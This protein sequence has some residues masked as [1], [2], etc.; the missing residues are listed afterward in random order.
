MAVTIELVSDVS[1]VIKGAGKVAER[2]ADVSDS[3]VDLARDSQRSGD[4]IETAMKDAGRSAEHIDDGLAGAGQAADAFEDKARAAF[5]A[6]SDGASKAGDKAAHETKQGFDKSGEAVETFKDEAKS[7]L[8]EVT[9]SFSGD[10][11]SAVDLIQGTLGGLVADLGP[12][13]LVGGAVAALAIGLAKAAADGEAERVNRIGEAAA[14][15]AADI[16]AVGGSLRD[17]DFDDRMHE[18][19]M[20]IQD[21]REWWELWQDK[22]LTGSQLIEKQAKEAGLGFK[23]MF[24]GASGSSEDA[25]KALKQID[26]VLG[27]LQKKTHT[28]TF[29]EFGREIEATDPALSK[30]IKALEDLRGR[31][32]ENITVQEDAAHVSDLMA[33]ADVALAGE[34]DKLKEATDKANDELER[35]AQA[36]DEAAGAAMDS[37]SAELD[38]NEKLKQNTE[39]I[40]ANGKATDTKSAAGIANNK[41]LLDSAQ[42]SL[43]LEAAMIREGAA[44][45]DVTA[46][47]QASR[48]AFIR[49]A[50]AAGYTNEEAR[51]LADR[52]GL[53][54]KNVDTKVQAHNVQQ[55]K[56]EINGL[57]APV[58]VPV[59]PVIPYQAKVNYWTALADATRPITQS[60]SM[61]V[62]KNLGGASVP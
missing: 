19:G 45:G 1:D 26:I 27:E 18:W 56:D 5:K 7:N 47:T 15:L 32:Q 61:T 46:K 21:T 3:L 60:V 10:M 34:E 29:D 23:D 51:K 38:Y 55:T 17:V 54:P 13:G 41:T 33:K 20:A 52:Y 40:K 48:D 30:R 11:D 44:A 25:H 53:I 49:Q 42:A 43:A 9:S 16:E 58:Q 37:M 31:V 57:G 8:S 50:E 59:H 35:K 22:A 14:T 36:L 2:F 62:I 24:R 6:M 39:D 4:K 12:A 28:G